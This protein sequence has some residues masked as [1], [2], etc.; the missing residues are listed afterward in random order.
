MEKQ[1]PASPGMRLT[2]F[3][4]SMLSAIVPAGLAVFFLANGGLVGGALFLSL[5]IVILMIGSV[6]AFWVAIIID[7]QALRYRSLHGRR[8]DRS[9]IGSLRIVRGGLQA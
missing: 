5:A 8:V 2:I 6:A 7:G 9:A 4:I 3:I 1:W